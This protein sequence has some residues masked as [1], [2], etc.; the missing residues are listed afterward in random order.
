[1]WDF[2]WAKH[3][4][5]VKRSE[6]KIYRRDDCNMQKLSYLPRHIQSRKFTRKVVE[7]KQKIKKAADDCWAITRTHTHRAYH[8][9][10]SIYFPRIRR[11]YTSFFYNRFFLRRHCQG[12]CHPF[13][14]TTFIWIHVWIK[15]FIQTQQTTCHGIRKWKF[16]LNSFYFTALDMM[17]KVVKKN[18]K[19]AE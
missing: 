7:V 12:L 16:L 6:W 4:R 9:T 13:L 14:H 2:V 10:S 17:W 5:K 18:N 1:L 8:V 11:L 3:L 19:I 15:H